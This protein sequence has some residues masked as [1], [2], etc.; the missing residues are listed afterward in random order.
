MNV[1]VSYEMNTIPDLYNP[2]D[3]KLNVFEGPL[4]L[5][6]HLIRKKELNIY[7][8]PLSELTASYLAYLALMQTINLDLAGEFLETAALLI[9]IKSRQLLPQPEVEEEGEEEDP[10]E[11]LRQR[12]IE[13]QRY[14]QA[15]Y[16]LSLRDL[17]GRDVF[18]RPTQEHEKKAELSGDELIFEELSVYM[19]M[20]AFQKVIHR[21][22]RL[23]SH[24]VEPEVYRIED[25]INELILHF[26][27]FRQCL[28]EDLFDADTTR[29]SIILTF[30]SLLEMVKMKL[31][32]LRQITTF[33]AIHCIAHED[34][35]KNEK[36]WHEMV[37]K[38]QL[39][40][41]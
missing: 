11:L 31:L 23:T 2:L 26:A 28:F 19:L 37:D 36:K 12:L 30:M 39:D 38:D 18:S 7:E 10:E 1:P 27:Q 4:D 22:P 40:I 13:Y 6:L 35:R 29:P 15:A 5:L 17:L 14:K 34:F 3:V 8:V 33:G 16:E 24:K 25:R 41:V 21:K 9:L 20:E 32:C